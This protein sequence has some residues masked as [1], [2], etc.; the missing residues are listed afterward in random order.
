MGGGELREN[1]RQLLSRKDTTYIYVLYIVRKGSHS[2]K[3]VTGVSCFRVSH[4]ILGLID[5]STKK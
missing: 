2:W 4:V 5:S 3:S 1:R